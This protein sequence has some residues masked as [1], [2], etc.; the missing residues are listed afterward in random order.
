MNSK[1][2]VRHTFRHGSNILSEA[3]SVFSDG[4]RLLSGSLDD[5]AC[6]WDTVTGRQL[7]E[8]VQLKE[9]TFHCIAIPFFN[10]CIMFDAGA[11]AGTATTRM[12]SMWCVC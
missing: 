8:Y 1:G 3:V 11:G 9:L 6:V 4:V 5:T 12:L 2:D 10:S 7:F